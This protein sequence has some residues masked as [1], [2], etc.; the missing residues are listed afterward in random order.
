MRRIAVAAALALS[1][2]GAL[3]ATA[4]ADP[5]VKACGSVT[6]TVNGSSVVDQAQ[7][8]VLPPPK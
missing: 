3:A 5:V 6:I 2:F 8:Q 4:S 7:C 1:S